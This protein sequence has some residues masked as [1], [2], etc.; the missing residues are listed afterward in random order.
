M[1]PETSFLRKERKT[2]HAILTWFKTKHGWGPPHG[3]RPSPSG[4]IPPA[5]RPARP[6]ARSPSPALP[7]RPLV[8]GWGMAGG[9]AKSPPWSR[10]L[11]QWLRAVLLG[12]EMHWLLLSLFP[13][14]LPLPLPSL[15]TPEL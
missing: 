7:W 4:P 8:E 9:H 14:L 10:L 12:K 15:C 13:S 6:P 11:W 1:V 5:R 2:A 3:D